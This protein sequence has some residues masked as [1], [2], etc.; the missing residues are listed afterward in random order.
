[1]LLYILHRRPGPVDVLAKPGLAVF[2][3]MPSPMIKIARMATVQFLQR[4]L[5]PDRVVLEGAAIVGLM[6]VWGGLF[7]TGLRSTLGRAPIQKF[8]I[9]RLTL[10]RP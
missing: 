10:G 5:S 6:E 1:V 2:E 7:P 8:R 9:L 3:D 4:D